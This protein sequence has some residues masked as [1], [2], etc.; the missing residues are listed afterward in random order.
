MA[1]HR[2]HA[3]RGVAIAGE[4]VSGG[5]VDDL[6]RLGIGTQLRAP[7][8]A[9]LRCGRLSLFIVRVRL[10]SAMLLNDACHPIDSPNMGSILE[11]IKFPK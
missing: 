7:T 3:G 6:P 1:R 4:F 2:F 5:F 11:N 8:T 9:P 10:I